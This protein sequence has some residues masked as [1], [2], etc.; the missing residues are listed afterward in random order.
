VTGGV[1]GLGR[2]VVEDKV[3]PVKLTVLRQPTLQREREKSIF[4]FF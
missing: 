4:R 2:L 1:G 3:V